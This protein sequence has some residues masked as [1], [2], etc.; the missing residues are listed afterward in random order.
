[1]RLTSEASLGGGRA[2]TNL[3]VLA[4][5]IA[6][7]SVALL[8]GAGAVAAKP[9]GPHQYTLID[10][11]TFGGPT[12][13]VDQPGR[14]I[15]RNGALIGQ[16]DTT[17]PDSDIPGV[18]VYHA[19][20]YRDGR[21]TDLGAL[22]GENSSYVFEV[23]G[24][25]IGA[26]G[27]ENG[28]TD[29]FT[30]GPAG[31]PVIYEEGQVVNLGTL[32]GGN[33]GFALSI[34]DRGQ[35]AGFSTNGTPDPFSCIIFCWGYE[36]HTVVWQD[37]VMTDIGTLGGPDAFV[38]NINERGQVAGWSFTSNVA[39]ASTGF[40]TMDPFLW[41]NGHM[42]DLGTLG[43]TMAV[44]NWM[45]NAGQVV[46]QSNLAG[47]TKGHPFLWDGHQLI[48]L[49]TLGGDNGTANW[50]SD[51]GA[52]IGF[53]DVADGT[54]HAFLWQNGHLQDLP[55]LPG[56]PCSSAWGVNNQ[57][58]VVGY[59]SNCDH[60]HP[61]GT[62]WRNGVAYNL[63]DLVAPSSLHVNLGSFINDQ[64]QIAGYAVLS[65]GNARAFLMTPNVH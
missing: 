41:Q 4:S 1:M 20:S 11:G 44:E 61:Q 60:S 55:P 36:T 51:N 45:N 22:P 19:F 59:S 35:V 25:G 18:N 52:V 56:A 42:R 12:S 47:D 17:T 10:P 58:D 32:P 26:G 24:Q 21:L 28:L 34:N 37:G 43:G 16:A 46:G 49:G 13:M 7:A 65:N 38:G 5:T 50:V 40:P 62:L 57:G 29:P 9:P 54:H 2:R 14:L 64:G 23:N 30:G 33:E 15:T 63:N 31:S 3:A 53:A 48:D 27:S 6:I 39:N 8:A